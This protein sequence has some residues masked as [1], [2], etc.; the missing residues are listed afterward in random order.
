MFFYNIDDF[1]VLNMTLQYVLFLRKLPC[2]IL[3][4]IVHFKQCHVELKLY[5]LFKVFFAGVIWIKGLV[6]SLGSGSLSVSV[7]LTGVYEVL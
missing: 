1:V 2:F 3:N 6:G 4:Q 7:T 5:F